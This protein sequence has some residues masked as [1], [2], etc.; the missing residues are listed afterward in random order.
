MFNYTPLTPTYPPSLLLLSL[1][2]SLSLSFSQSYQQMK[3][4][5]QIL[6]NFRVTSKLLK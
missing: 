3:E 1:S 4:T 5:F 2:L 6:L